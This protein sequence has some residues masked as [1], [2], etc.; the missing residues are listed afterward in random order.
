MSNSLKY[1]VC[2][3]VGHGGK[4]PGVTNGN[5]FE[6]DYVLKVANFTMDLLAGDNIPVFMTR[7]NDSFLTLSKRTEIANNAQSTIFVS[8]HF[9]G[10]K[11][12]SAHG[13]ETFHFPGSKQGKILASN[14]QS[15]MIQT[16]DGRD[17]GVKSANFLVLRQ[18]TM[19]A[20]LVEP[21]FITN[22]KEKNLIISRD[23]QL[24]CARAI[25][26]GILSFIREV[27]K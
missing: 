17:R 11:D 26:N 4:D 8:L 7:Y 16:L 9:N 2:L 3:D 19:P 6:K 12:P 15:K 21:A 1:L 23:F 13:I 27:N 22:E 24:D 25:T 5:Y 10:A 14:I 20:V 18:T